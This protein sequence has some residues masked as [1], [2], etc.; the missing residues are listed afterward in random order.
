MPPADVPISPGDGDRTRSGDRP[1]RP[2]RP[3]RAERAVDR[4]ERAVSREDRAVDRAVER[5]CVSK[6]TDEEKKEK[7]KAAGH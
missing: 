2:E 3:E 6:K 7:R 1:D 5:P 4:P